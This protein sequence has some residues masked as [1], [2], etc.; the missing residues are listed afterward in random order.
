MTHTERPPLTCHT[1]RG[2]LVYVRL[3][4]WYVHEDGRA[5][6]RASHPQHEGDDLADLRAAC[7]SSTGDLDA[8]RAANPGTTRLDLHY[9]PDHVLE[10]VRAASGRLDLLDALI[11]DHGIPEASAWPAPPRQ[12]TNKES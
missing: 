2:K 8:L 3:I 6:D 5:Y 4:D 1:C 11:A 9:A 7:P 10:A 12:S